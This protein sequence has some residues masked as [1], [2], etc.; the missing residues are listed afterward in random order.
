MQG[1]DSFLDFAF[2]FS[3]SDKIKCPCNNCLNVCYKTRGE[4][5]FH[6]LRHGVLQSYII[7]DKHG[8]NDPSSNEAGVED[9]CDGEDILDM[10][11]VATDVVGMDLLGND[12]GEDDNDTPQEPTKEAAR[13]Y[14]LLK[15]YKEPL[16]FDGSNVSKLVYIVKLLHLKSLNRWSDTTFIE[17]LK[18]QNETLGAYLIPMMSVERSLEIWV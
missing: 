5:R 7:W 14:R 15:D 4:V 1:V 6:L 11:E 10:L 17:L 8:E 12:E 9:N 16:V 3:C 18:F 2:G 13:F